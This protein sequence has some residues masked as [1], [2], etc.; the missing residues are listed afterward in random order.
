M[1]R[2]FASAR[3]NLASNWPR[4]QRN[5]HSKVGVWGYRPVTRRVFKG[6]NTNKHNKTTIYTFVPESEFCYEFRSVIS[7]QLK[8][9]SCFLDNLAI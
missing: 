9:C 5:Y 4:P 1:L 6:I 7:S 3:S 8:D 2:N